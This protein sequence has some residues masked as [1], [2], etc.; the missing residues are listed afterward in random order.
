M[1]DCLP[2]GLIYKINKLSIL[3]IE[4]RLVVVDAVLLL[5][6]SGVAIVV[7]DWLCGPVGITCEN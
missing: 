3:S 2:S 7:S 6:D 4:E 5:G 1:T